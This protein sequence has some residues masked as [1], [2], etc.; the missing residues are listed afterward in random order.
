VLAETRRFDAKWKLEILYSAA[1][2]NGVLVVN[3]G[4]QPFEVTALQRGRASF[5]RVELPAKLVRESR[6]DPGEGG[7][8]FC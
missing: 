4:G 6:G 8:T 7:K 1:G 5:H 2:E 3:D